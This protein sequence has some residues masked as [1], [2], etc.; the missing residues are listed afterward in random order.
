M[1]GNVS[2]TGTLGSV[3]PVCGGQLVEFSPVLATTDST[4]R[5]TD[6]SRWL[7]GCVV[8]ITNTDS[9]CYGLSTVIAGIDPTTLN[10]QMMAFENGQSPRKGDLCLINGF[11]FSG[12]GFGFDPPLAY[13]PYTADS[14]DPNFSDP[15]VETPLTKTSTYVYTSPTPTL[16]PANPILANTGGCTFKTLLNNNIRSTPF[17]LTLLP[18]DPDNRNPIGGANSDYTA[19]DIQHMVLAGQIPFTLAYTDTGGVENAIQIHTSV[20]P[21]LP[22]ST[23]LPSFFRPE[24][25]G[26]WMSKVAVSG[27]NTIAATKSLVNSAGTNASSISVNVCDFSFL[28]KG[29]ATYIGDNAARQFDQDYGPLLRSIMMRP[30]PADHPNFTGSNPNF[31]AVWDGITPVGSGLEQNSNNSGNNTSN[32]TGNVIQF[33]GMWDVDN[34][35]D[36]VPDSVWVDLGMPVRTAADGTLYKPL[37][38]ILC[39]DLDGRL[40][41]NAHGSTCQT[42]VGPNTNP[43][44]WN[45]PDPQNGYVADLLAA[46]STGTVVPSE[47]GGASG[48]V[49]YMPAGA[50]N[51]SMANVLLPTGTPNLQAAWLPRGIGYG[52][53]E[54]NLLP[55]M[56]DPVNNPGSFADAAAVQRY[57]NIL[58]GNKNLGLC[59]RYG[60]VSKEMGSIAPQA[61]VTG[62]MSPLVRNKWYDCYLATSDT[63]TYWDQGNFVGGND[64]YGTPPDP[65]GWGTVA[66]DPKGDPLFLSMGFK[67]GAKDSPLK[68]VPYEINL[69]SNAPRGLPDSPIDSPFSAAELERVLRPFDRDTGSLP[70]RLTALTLTSGTSTPVLSA[71]GIPVPVPFSVLQA[72]RHEVTTEQWDV[73]TTVPAI[74]PVLRWA[75]AGTL[76]SAP[77]HVPFPRHVVDLFYANYL[78]N[79]YQNNAPGSVTIGGLQVAIQQALQ[80]DMI[81]VEMLT[82]LKM[83]LN[84]PLSMGQGFTQCTGPAGGAA[85]FNNYFSYDPTGTNPINSGT[86]DAYGSNWYP[87]IYPN[88]K[89]PVGSKDPYTFNAGGSVWPQQ[90][91]ARQ[92]MAKYLFILAM[93]LYNRH[94]S[95][96]TPMDG[97]A[98][99]GSPRDFP[100]NKRSIRNKTAAA[101]ALTVEQQIFAQDRIAQ[102]A[103]NCAMFATNDSIM[104]PFKYDANF[105]ATGVWN[106]QDDKINLYPSSSGVPPTLDQTGGAPSSAWSGAASRRTS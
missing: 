70:N 106:L 94:G 41:L 45:L 27:T 15:C 85:S 47:F 24:L 101:L 73:P 13:N 100:Y 75:L 66:V 78:Y 81:P 7:G 77:V 63:A 72:K 37:F 62:A 57:N 68:N 53:A 49:S 19:P 20:N 95:V 91:Q 105:Y 17:F 50:S 6:P 76:N 18:N 9:P 11:P 90:I 21:I 5:W 55:V 98:D 88:G 33:G 60:E 28:R 8:T 79:L 61:G 80:H 30:N 92:R 51:V 4:A 2:L 23:P 102:W 36:G 34:D 82:G 22:L 48:T 93:M 89:T 59:G 84:R 71:S 52:P 44:R 3:S 29:S 99:N 39:V 26:Y 16:P 97:T 69:A 25:V 38:A 32:T 56:A 67:P 74:P 103:I 87:S 1:Y 54:I 86:D 46:S 40:N 35:G 58:S 96:Q 31:N 65:L 42:Q 14:P 64:N 83:N 43:G 12:P 10:P 104:V